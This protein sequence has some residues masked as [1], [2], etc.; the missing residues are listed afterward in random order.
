MSSKSLFTQTILFLVLLLSAQTAMAKLYYRY[1]GAQGTPVLD[2]NMPP[3]EYLKNGYSVVNDQGVVVET[4]APRKT[5]AEQQREAEGLKEKK[6]QEALHRERAM[7]DSVLMGTYLSVRDIFAVR[8]RKIAALDTLIDITRS[9]IQR[10]E[11]QITSLRKQAI[12][13]ERAG[14]PI[15][16][17]HQQTLN[18]TAH[19][20]QEN[21][22]AIYSKYLEQ[23]RINLRAAMDAVIFEQLN[24]NKTVD[25]GQAQEPALPTI[26]GIVEC[27]STDQCK[28]AWQLTKEYIQK[29]TK[30][31][32]SL[33]TDEYIMTEPAM[34][35]N[36]VSVMAGQLHLNNQRGKIVLLTACEHGASGAAFCQTPAV[37]SI[38]TGFASF[39]QSHLKAAVQ[40]TTSNH[41][42]P[43][44]IK[45]PQVTHQP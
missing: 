13:L 5:E 14:R 3:P 1:I 27:D 39:V 16:A 45:P 7:H 26:M 9:N 35:A 21:K 10:L 40:P 8:D 15:P 34:A 2:D 4:V 36:E 6:R 19:Q 22:A 24:K 20:I 25:A 12:A 11:D 23:Q 43:D 17:S 31:P 32:I 33:A 29:F 41:P 30:R 28:Q 37:K 44:E 42:S 18:N 38:Q